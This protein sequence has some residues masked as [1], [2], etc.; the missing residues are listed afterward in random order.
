MPLQS[1]NTPSKDAPPPAAADDPPSKPREW[2]TPPFKEEFLATNAKPLLKKEDAAKTSTLIN[3]E[4]LSESFSPSRTSSPG[5][6][7]RPLVASLSGRTSASPSASPKA[8][9]VGAQQPSVVVAAALVARAL[10]TNGSEIPRQQ[11]AIPAARSPK[12]RTPP[13]P[14]LSSPLSL[15]LGETGGS[16]SHH[17]LA[18][19]SGVP[20]FLRAGFGAST[21]CLVYLRPP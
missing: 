14:T 4:A 6:V 11:S 8:F 18:R 1:R 13:T 2:L 16:R 5:V 12:A 10:A 17:W 9:P 21:L 15:T 3:T 19:P 20:V 7:S